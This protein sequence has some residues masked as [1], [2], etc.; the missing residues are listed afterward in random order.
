MEPIAIVGLGCRFPKAKNPAEFWQ[1]LREGV[2]AIAEVPPDRWDIKDF[3]D[4]E[5]STP[6]KANSRWGGFLDRVDGLDADF[7]G[8]TPGEAKQ[9]DPQQ[10]LVLEVGWEA[11]EN[12]GLAPDKLAGS[13]TGVFLGIGS[14]DYHKQVCYDPS[15]IDPYSSIGTSNSIAANRLSFLLD[16]RGPSMTVDTACSSSLV[17]VHLACQSLRLRES[18]L[19][20]AGGTNVMVRPG[21]TIALSKAGLLSA[22]G[23]CKT[24]DAL[25]DGYVRGEGCGM[26][27]LKRLEDALRDR[28]RILAIVRGSATNQDGTSNG[29][30][31]PNRHSQEAAIRQALENA[32]VQPAEISYVEAQGTGTT[33]GDAIEVKALKAVLMQG[34]EGDLPCWI[35]SVKTNIGHLESA[36]GIASLI[37][38]ILSLQQGEIPPH[39]HL[40]QLNPY[41]SLA[42]TPFAIPKAPQDWSPSSK[43]RFAGVSAFGFGG[44]NCHLVVA[45][46]PKSLKIERSS[47]RSLHILALSAKTPAALQELAGRYESYLAS[48]PEAS[49]ADM[50]FTVNTGRSHFE[51]RL[52]AVAA[53]TAQLR[54]K[55]TDFSRDR[56]T[57][58]A[59]SG[60]VGRKKRR[61]IA[62]VFPSESRDRLSR[63]CQ[64]YA[65]ESTFRA[66]VDRCARI[67]GFETE[68][69]LVNILDSDLDSRDS[70]WT[71]LALFAFQYALAQLW[72]SWG[73]LP[74]AAI[75]NGVGEYVAACTSGKLSL[76]M[77]I[78]STLEDAGGEGAKSRNEEEVGKEGDRMASATLVAA[79]YP[80]LSAQLIPSIKTLVAAGYD[81]FIEISPQPTNLWEF[82]GDRASGIALTW[83]STV[84]AGQSPW[85]Q[86]LQ[87]LGELYVRGLPVDWS[88]VD[89]DYVRDRLELPTYP[90]QR[91]RYWLDNGTNPEKSDLKMED[92]F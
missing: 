62:F 53:S 47:D 49:L 92:I 38:T 80:S 36:A 33:L 28:D 27:V 77:A 83:L 85:Q 91:Q 22:G 56:E 54:Q 70:R 88:A 72:Q 48:H 20:L 69:S 5:P 58:G 60:R 46:S 6:G 82:A 12:A 26:V 55:L 73:I 84:A 23:R 79:S 2:D 4:P 40:Q 71:R 7:F 67:G 42:G 24:F 43:P 21:V 66:S 41:I 68:K 87:T 76:E 61:K 64:L 39:L 13:K 74:K 11:L 35:G 44:T 90:F 14:Y 65:T 31:A 78:A 89:K 34:R 37:K 57:A 18:D 51:Y 16:L 19:C 52:A 9:M 81:L 10:R 8:I 50:C 45:E 15:N 25:A 17:S 63:G 1:L 32:G 29:L 86:I 59:T 75:G 3:Y 30:T